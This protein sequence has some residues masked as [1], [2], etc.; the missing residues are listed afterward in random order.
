[1]KGSWGANAVTEAQA[2]HAPGLPK[3]GAYRVEVAHQGRMQ[4]CPEEIEAIRKC[5]D[6]LLQGTWTDK[7]GK[8]RPITTDD[9]IVVAPFNAQVNALTE[10]LSEISVGTVDKFQG[11]E[12]PVTLLSMTSSSS[13]ETP[14]GLG[15]LFSRERINVAMSR[16]KVLSIAFVSRQLLL[17]SCNTVDEVRMVNPLCALES[18]K[19]L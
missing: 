16:G 14:R 10:A 12:A 9:I 11:Q 4:E 18:V 2:V 17:A 1:M 5:I 3:S 6:Q 19:L 8:E 15:F 13:E 7:K